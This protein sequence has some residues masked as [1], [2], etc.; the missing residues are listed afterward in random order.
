MYQLSEKEIEFILND[1]KSRG[2]EMEDLQMNLLDHIC[3]ILEEEY[4]AEE[5]F[6]HYYSKVIVRFFKSE[7]KE[8]EVETTILMSNKHYYAMKKTMIVSGISAA[9]LLSVGSIFK[10]MHWPGA[11][12]ILVLGVAFL[13]LLF[14]PL[15]F[16][17]KKAETKTKAEK[18]ILGVGA[19]VGILYCLATLFKI[20]HWPGAS[21]LWYATI[22]LS[23]F[24]FIPIYF[25]N[26]IKKE[27]RKGDT[28]ITT[29][30][31]IGATSV[32]FM[33]MNTRPA[34]KQLELKMYNYLKS[35]E[36]LSSM[37]HQIALQ[38]KSAEDSLLLTIDKECD[39][40]KSLIYQN[41]FGEEKSL[42]AL[43]LNDNFFED[44]GIGPNFSDEQALGGRLI[45]TLTDDVKRYNQTAKQPI[46]F[47]TTG[48][49]ENLGSIANYNIY[50]V[51]S[52]LVNLQMYIV[53]QKS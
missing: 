6:E 17:T 23:A 1:I 39:Q 13:S 16:L 44:S 11:A 53:Y 14:L 24:V 7:L 32:L 25:F 9:I 46:P 20:Q 27:E 12:I 35:E 30:L 19:L 5:D 36:L 33:M 49:G 38:P 37:K 10:L 29:I 3:C 51:L 31:L 41:Y 40:I 42:A 52:S 4:T 50:S 18:W 47:A 21:L 43:N 48:L 2:V 15:L 34:K 28:I 45:R 8:I 22:V 26:G